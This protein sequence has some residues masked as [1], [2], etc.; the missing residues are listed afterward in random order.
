[1]H[2]AAIILCTFFHIIT[3]SGVP[4]NCL[5]PNEGCRESKKVE[6]HCTRPLIMIYFKKKF[7]G[8]ECP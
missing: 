7:L 5:K 8:K 3:H 6:K 4:P 1:M 2:F